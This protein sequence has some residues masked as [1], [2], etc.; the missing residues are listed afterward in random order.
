L[1]GAEARVGGRP[2]QVPPGPACTDVDVI[3]SF[4]PTYDALGGHH[5]DRHHEGSLD[6]ARPAHGDDLSH[7]AVAVVAAAIDAAGTSNDGAFTCDALGRLAT[8]ARGGTS[9][10]TY[11]YLGTT[12]RVARI[13][14]DV[15]GNLDSMVSPAAYRLGVSMAV[16]HRVA[17]AISGSRHWG[18]LCSNLGAAECRWVPLDRAGRWGGLRGSNP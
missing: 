16:T 9:T 11:S 3:R 5:P 13:D 2:K 10:D 14:N 18:N 6:H 1:A 8:R 4:V 12:E 7:V 17:V 15:S